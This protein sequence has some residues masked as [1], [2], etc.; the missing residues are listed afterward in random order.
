MS[1]R[2]CTIAVLERFSTSTGAALRLIYQRGCWCEALGTPESGPLQQRMGDCAVTMEKS[3]STTTYPGREC[4]P[5][6][7]GHHHGAAVLHAL[8]HAFSA[9]QR[10]A[11]WPGRACALYC[12][13]TSIITRPGGIPCWATS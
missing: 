11:C 7:F 5:G 9:H 8:D 4:Q 1:L 3:T 2:D 10:S 12:N 6:W 13:S